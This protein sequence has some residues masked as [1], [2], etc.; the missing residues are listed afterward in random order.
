MALVFPAF[1][2]RP[3]VFPK[4]LMDLIV[5]SNELLSASSVISGSSAYCEILYSVSPMKTPFYRIHNLHC[6]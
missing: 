2:E 1:K 4:V 3:G 5:S 6:L